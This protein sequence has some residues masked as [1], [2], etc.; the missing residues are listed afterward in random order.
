MELVDEI[1]SFVDNELKDSEIANRLQKLIADDKS[2]RREYVIQK[3]IKDLLLER[4]SKSTPPSCLCE[5]LRNKIN[6]EIKKSSP[7]K[8]A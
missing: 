2:L 5:K 8:K 1:T 3:S 6:L 4:L 7:N